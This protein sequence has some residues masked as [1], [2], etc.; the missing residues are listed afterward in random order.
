MAKHDTSAEKKPA[1]TAQ[2]K[3]NIL[4]IWGDDIG[5]SILVALRKG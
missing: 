5:Q 1:G 3:P 4:I 2:G